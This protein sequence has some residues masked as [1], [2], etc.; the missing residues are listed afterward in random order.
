M[1]VEKP[2]CS[3]VLNVVAQR[4]RFGVP[5]TGTQRRSRTAKSRYALSVAVRWKTSFFNTSV[6]TAGTI[7]ASVMVKNHEVP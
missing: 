4:G 2:G 7:P 3:G 6:G 5:S 1:N